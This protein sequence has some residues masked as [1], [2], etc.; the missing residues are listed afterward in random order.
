MWPS[1]SQ[2]NFGGN[3]TRNWVHSERAWAYVWAGRL[4][5]LSTT[6]YIGPTLSSSSSELFV[7]CLIERQN[8][9]C[10]EHIR[11]SRSYIEVRLKKIMR[12]NRNLNTYL[13]THLH[14]LQSLYTYYLRH[15]IFTMYMYSSHV[16][17]VQLCL[18]HPNTT[19]LTTFT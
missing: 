8:L 15:L 5:C 3:Q 7:W 10:I 16:I 6:G 14:C 17:V 1:I 11:Q 18:Q 2:K 13:S 19:N 9:R 12:R 4:W